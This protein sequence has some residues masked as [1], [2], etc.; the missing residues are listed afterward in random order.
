MKIYTTPTI[1]APGSLVRNTLGPKIPWIAETCCRKPAGGPH[2]SFGLA[3]SAG[4]HRL[5]E[6]RRRR[7]PGGSDSVR[8][9]LMLRDRVS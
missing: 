4:Y 7:R 9:R 5:D 6:I 8:L 3:N 2:L 1:T